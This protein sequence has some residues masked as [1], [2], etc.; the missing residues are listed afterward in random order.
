MESG[1]VPEDA[2][3]GAEILRMERP[4][5]AGCLIADADPGKYGRNLFHQERE[6]FR[7]HGAGIAAQD[8][9]AEKGDRSAAGCF[10]QCRM[11]IGRDRFEGNGNEFRRGLLR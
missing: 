2:V 1:S 8:G 11:L 4:G 7:A 5:H 10:G 3:I 6:V 9:F